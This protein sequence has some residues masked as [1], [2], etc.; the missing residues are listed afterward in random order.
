MKL[1]SKRLFVIVLCMLISSL[2]TTIFLRYRLKKCQVEDAICFEKLEYLSYAVA[3]Y[4]EKNEGQ[5]PRDFATIKEHIALELYGG[6]VINP[7]TKEKILPFAVFLSPNEWFYDCRT[8]PETFIYGPPPLCCLGTGIYYPKEIDDSGILLCSLRDDDSE[9]CSYVYRGNDLNSECYTNP[10]LS[11]DMMFAYCK[12]WH[13]RRRII[14]YC[15]GS[16]KM[17]SKWGFEGAIKH[18]NDCRRKHGLPEKEMEN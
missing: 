3:H 9:T 13:G 2:A 18:D 17:E 4:I 14:V 1:I 5:V 7:K 6:W 12:H 8:R 16:I 10:L 11:R 15:N